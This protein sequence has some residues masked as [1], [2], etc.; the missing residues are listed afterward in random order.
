M[1][2]PTL[3]AA[4]AI[5]EESLGGLRGAIAGASP[6]TLNARPAGDDTN[7]IAVLAVHA[8]HSTRMWF[9]IST[10]QGQ[11]ERDRPAEFVVRA[12]D[13]DG[14]L[15]TVEALA[16][17][18]RASLDAAGPFEPGA[19]RTVTW[20]ASGEVEEVT[21]AWGLIHG[22]EHLREH[23]AHAQLTR[24]LLDARA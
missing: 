22:L 6:D 9:A 18:C 16:D 2:D 13:A 19:A 1:A 5:F 24:Q 12:E 14:L 23:V 17:A 20:P 8:M 3:E 15:A 21:A 7:P 11:P 10:G 4:R